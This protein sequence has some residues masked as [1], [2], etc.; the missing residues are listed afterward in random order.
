VK[1][2]EQPPS[3]Q[4]AALKYRGEKFAE[5]WFKP[6]GEPFALSFRIPRESFQIPGVGPRL[7][8]ENVLRAVAV[9]IEEVEAW[10][11]GGVARAGMH[12]TDPDLRKPVSPPPPDVPHLDIYVR[13]KPPHVATPDEHR[14]AEMPP[15]QWQDLEARWRA[16]LGLEATIDAACLRMDFLRAELEAAVKKTLAPDERV[17]AMNLDVA[18]WNKAKNRAHF[19]LPKAREFIHRATWAK[20][21][22]EKKKLEEIFKKYIEPRVP[23]PEMDKVPEQMDYLLKL[24]QVLSAQGV[25]VYQ[26]CQS[27]AGAIQGALSSLLRNAAANAAKKR[28]AAREKGKHF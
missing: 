6:E 4:W 1:F 13:L 21:A 24:R 9:T 16:I 15:E 8:P 18:Q 25:T 7:T 22:P 10:H 11:H 3:Q 14:E 17:H 26:E 28:S 23:F 2:S 5:V 19:A 27:I 20:G 12:A